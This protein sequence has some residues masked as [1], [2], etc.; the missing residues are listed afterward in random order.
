MNK[1]DLA[2]LS[3]DERHQLLLLASGQGRADV[4]NDVLATCVP[5][6]GK[7]TIAALARVDAD[8]WSV[9]HHAVWHRRLDV[10]RL[11]LRAGVPAD[12]VAT[13]GAHAGHTARGLLPD[14]SE[15][16]VGAVSA[17]AARGVR[18]AFGAELLQCAVLGDVARTRQLLRGGA[19]PQLRLGPVGA[20]GPTVAE[21]A[22]ELGGGARH[23]PA[24]ALL[25]HSRIAPRV[26]GPPPTPKAPTP[27]A[28]LRIEVLLGAAAFDLAFHTVGT[29]LGD[30]GGGDMGLDLAAWALGP[31]TFV[32]Y[33][34]R[35]TLTPVV[36]PEWCPFCHQDAA[37][38]S[39]PAFRTPLPSYLIRRR[40]REFENMHVSFAPLSVSQVLSSF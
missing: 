23:N 9:L 3:D 31:R 35:V 1:R 40:Y 22:A 21:L 33:H 2:S 5:E 20:A 39:I 16:G 24:M 17:A 6:K 37:E 25:V 13:G 29:S 11:L 12:L 32:W 4:L 38:A 15:V 26:V 19:S 30:D 14:D 18:Q 28:L 8:G 36:A 27:P 34:I 10:V 7:D